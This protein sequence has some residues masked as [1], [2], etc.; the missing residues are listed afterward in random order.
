MRDH[1]HFH[2]RMPRGL[3]Q[4]E[5]VAHG[6]SVPTERAGK[7]IARGQR[8][9]GQCDRCVA[10]RTRKRPCGQPRRVRE[11]PLLLDRARGADAGRIGAVDAAMERHCGQSRSHPVPSTY[12]PF[13]AY[14]TTE[15]RQQLLDTIAEAIDEIGVALAAL[16]DAY[17]Q[18]D[19]YNA[20]NLEERLFRPVQVAFGRA[21]R[22][23]AEFAARYSLATREFAPQAPPGAASRGVKGFLE[24]A[25]ESVTVA[26]SMLAR[27]QDSMMPVEVG[28]EALRG[29]L[30]EVRRLLGPLGEDARRFVSLLGR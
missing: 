30:A 4:R 5:E 18:L 14:V 8:T 25:V 3:A 12:A 7:W 15:A 19:E 6:A 9:P 11:P 16:G 1:T 21:K 13:M 26:D 24:S 17:E 2:M 23:H 28:D 10:A 29:G 20:D 27:L 22:T